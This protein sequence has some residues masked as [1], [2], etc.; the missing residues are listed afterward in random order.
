MDV[1]AFD[2]K[3]TARVP[4]TP[5]GYEQLRSEQSAGP[6]RIELEPDRLRV[7]IVK[8]GQVRLHQ[9][10]RRVAEGASAGADVLEAT[11]VKGARGWRLLEVRPRTAGILKAHEAT[12][13]IPE[14]RRTE[15][16]A[17]IPG[18]D[19]GTMDKT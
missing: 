1:R 8:P 16:G 9:P 18:P 12:G 2:R 5:G 11:A 6:W 17:V 4:V 10:Y 14:P 3:Q 7:G 13:Q 19:P 15:P